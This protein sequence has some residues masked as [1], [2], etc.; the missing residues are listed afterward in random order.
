LNFHEKELKIENF[1]LCDDKYQAAAKYKPKHMH[2][3]RDRRQR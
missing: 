3:G 2:E 1:V